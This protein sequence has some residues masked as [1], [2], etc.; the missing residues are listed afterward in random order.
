MW[1]TTETSRVCNEQCLDYVMITIYRVN[2]K[3]NQII[4][5]ALEDR[6]GGWTGR[7]NLSRKN[8]VWVARDLFWSP[9]NHFL[10]GFTANKF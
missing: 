5:R 8:D 7:T 3:L 2:G 9:K 10:F 1:P 4:R 6:V